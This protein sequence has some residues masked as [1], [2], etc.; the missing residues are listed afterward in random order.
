MVE[1]LIEGFGDMIAEHSHANDVD[2]ICLCGSVIPIC[3]QRDK[4][5]TRYNEVRL[6][7]WNM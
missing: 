2:S 1:V 6:P 3:L 7:I 4:S 5:P